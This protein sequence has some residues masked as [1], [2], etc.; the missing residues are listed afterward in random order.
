MDGESIG[1]LNRS[2]AVSDVASRGTLHTD[3]QRES[4]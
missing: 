4:L 3:W 2:C 1:G